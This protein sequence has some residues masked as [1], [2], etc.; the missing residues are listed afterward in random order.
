MATS[1]GALCSD[2][3]I[4]QKLSLKM[5]LPYERETILHLFERIRKSEPTMD[6]FRRYDNELA[7]E[8]SRREP[9]YRWMAIRQNS[10]RTGHVN[11]QTMDGSYQFHRLIIETVP[12]HLSV[13]ALDVDYLDLMFGFDLECNDNHDEVVFEALFGHSPVRT[14]VQLPGYPESRV[15]DVQPVYGMSLDRRGDLQAY[16]EVKTRSRN[17]KGQTSRTRQEPISVLL[18]LRKYGPVQTINDLLP[19]FDLLR[20]HCEHLA[21]ERLVPDLLTPIARQITSSSA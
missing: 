8:S 19:I 3:Y 4:N 21:T 16:F 7:L 6:R 13:S 10:I 18:T 1:F 20:E 12:Y 5:D 17:R 15:I 14:L 2:F 9:E 11:P